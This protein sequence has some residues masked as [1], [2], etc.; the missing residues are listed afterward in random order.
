MAMRVLVVG[1]GGREQAL[2]SRLIASP[3]VGTVIVAPGNA[4][5]GRLARRLG[6]G[7]ELRNA[8]GAPLEV[9]R[10]ERIDLVVVGPEAPLCAGLVDELVAAGIP[11]F[12]PSR[13]AARLEGSK[14]FMKDFAVRHGIRTARHLRVSEPSE[15]GRAVAGFPAPPVVKADG[16]CAGKGVVV[17]ETHE[18]ALAAAE[19]MLTGSSFGDAGR[20]VVLEERLEGAEASVHA[21]SD[22]ERCFVLPAAQDHKRISDGDLGPNTGGMGSYAPAPL[23]TPALLQRI[24]DEV[25]D[26]TLRGMQ[27]D[28]VPYRGTL[29]A[30]LMITPDNEPMLLEFNVRFGDPETQALVHVL[31]GDFAQALLG[32]ATGRLDPG[33]VRTAEAHALC[34]VL[35]AEGY[36]GAP[37]TGDVIQGLDEAEA[38]PGVEIYHAG[39]RLD[40]DR[41]LTAG[42]RVLGVTAR[43]ATL[44]LARERAYQ[45]AELI[46]Y[47]GKQMRRDIGHRALG[48]LGF[49]P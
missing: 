48:G 31:D 1:S 47:P 45:A 40:G 25:L 6:G 14:A 30:G 9:A 7:K 35:A 42:G 49:R 15:L 21:V 13:L 10:S 19:R 33:A 29:Y 20:T 22:G 34:V 27:A 11:A 36:P 24:R 16:L 3:S 32:A 17:A 44:G 43:G 26:R 46:R 12:G 28:G 39:T 38:V 2:A 37:R 18:Q 5:T 8:A 23:V 41:V 4:G